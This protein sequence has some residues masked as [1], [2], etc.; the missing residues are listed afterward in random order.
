MSKAPNYYIVD[1]EA[2]PEIFHK[3]V[4]ARRMLD[5]GEEET[6]NQ[7][8]QLVGISRSAFYK[9]KDAVLRHSMVKVVN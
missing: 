6:V 1:A 7:A 9:Y 5:T 8:V 3:V 4:Q 2:L